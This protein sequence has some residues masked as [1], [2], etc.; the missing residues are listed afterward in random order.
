MATTKK[1]LVDRIAASTHTKQALVKAVVQEFFDEI[2]SEL[3]KGNRVEFRDFGVFETKISLPRM[4]QNPTTLKPP[5]DCLP[6]PSGGGAG[7]FN[8]NPARTA[9]RRHRMASLWP[10]H[11]SVTS[12]SNSRT[13]RTLAR[14]TGSSNL[15]HTNTP[16]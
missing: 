4:A 11:P 12:T 13:K 8:D 1:Q 10:I 2:I 7:T 9:H 6:V 3:V 16:E 5:G 15:A 14:P